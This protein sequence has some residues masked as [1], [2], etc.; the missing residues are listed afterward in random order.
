MKGID[1]E[2]SS[3][4]T[5]GIVGKTGAGKTTILE[6]ITRSYD[7]TSGEISIDGNLIREYDLSSLRSLISY[8]PQ[9]LFYFQIQ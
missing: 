8:V 5:L 7:V 3:G 1:F 6:L 9:N 4:K 2:I